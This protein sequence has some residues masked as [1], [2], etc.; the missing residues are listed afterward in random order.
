MEQHDHSRGGPK[1]LVFAAMD[2]L[3]GLEQ[4]LEDQGVN[5]RVA[6]G[7]AGMTRRSGA[8]L[9]SGDPLFVTHMLPSQQIQPSFVQATH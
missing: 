1:N 4:L 2:R 7:A 9:G 5:E 3:D 8:L 6:S